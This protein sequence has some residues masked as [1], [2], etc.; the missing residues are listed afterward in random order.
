MLGQLLQKLQQRAKK[1]AG[2]LAARPRCCSA[3]A[4]SCVHALGQ[5]PRPAKSAPS[6]V[7]VVALLPVG[8]HHRLRPVH[9]GN[10]G[11]SCVVCFVCIQLKRVCKY[12]RPA[13]QPLA[14]GTYQQPVS[15]IHVLC[16]GDV[17]GVALGGVAGKRDSQQEN[18]HTI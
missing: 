9:V 1:G 12:A 14:P 2:K 15:C 18:A 17:W 8:C 5:C 4:A 11:A 13:P 6:L 3:R 16:M 7:V 10:L